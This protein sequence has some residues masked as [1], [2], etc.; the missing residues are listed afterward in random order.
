MTA[1]TP[2]SS[3]ALSTSLNNLRIAEPSP[4]P[5]S[6]PWQ[7]DDRPAPPVKLDTA[8]A[9]PPLPI[10]EVAAVFGSDSD[11]EDS[12]GIKGVGDDIL[13]EFDPLANSEAEA[14]RDA[15]ANAESH[16]PPP[17]PKAPSPPPKGDLS[18][19]RTTSVDT[20]KD[21]SLPVPPPP[22]TQTGGAPASAPS[23]S[24][25]PVFASLARSF[26]SKLPRPRP[27]SMDSARVVP[28]PDKLA[29][30]AQQHAQPQQRGK[31]REIVSI[32]PDDEHGD[33]GA[34]GSA[35]VVSGRRDGSAESGSRRR[36]D[37]DG[38]Q[39][40][41]FQQFLEQMKLKAAEPVAKYLRSYV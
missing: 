26:S 25:F 39:T 23:P 12:N 30:A 2:T 28:S 6:N 33:A 14:A 20:S 21:A 11:R 15:W 18:H 24:A 31:Q 38:E 3:D 29:L 10:D 16:P 22:A 35:V 13:D 19:S 37:R 40:F 5:S 9:P 7:D 27:R 8:A 41:D 36:G 34:E 17:P 1:L 4:I 32:V